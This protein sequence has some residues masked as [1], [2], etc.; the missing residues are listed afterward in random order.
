MRIIV[1][2]SIVILAIVPFF[3]IAQS[4]KKTEPSSKNQVVIPVRLQT[5][6]TG[7][8]K[9][10]SKQVVQPGKQGL[11]QPTTLKKETDTLKIKARDYYK[12]GAKKA[13][14][15]DYAGAIKDFSKS[16]S[17]NR[18][19]IILT[20]RAYAYMLNSQYDSAIVDATEANN[21]IKNNSEA[22]MILGISYY[23]KQNLD[24]AYKFLI[25]AGRLQKT[26]PMIY[27]YLAAIK[28]LQKDYKSALL[29]YD[30]VVMRDSSYQD[31]FSNRGMMQHYLGN[32]QDAVND[33]SQAIK[34][35]SI[36]ANAYNNRAAARII[37][38]D[39]PPALSDLNTAIRL[40]PG[41]SNAYENR[42][43]VKLQMGDKEGACQDWTK[44][45]SMGLESS[46]ELI[47]KHCK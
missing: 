47:I 17:Y 24:E 42:G 8:S 13:E 9:S 35:D 22:L 39:Y 23:E 20:K 15:K 16:L 27:D 45:L 18:N 12:S 21:K 4:D 28:F 25:K 30:S 37:L 31:V 5:D 7:K 44:A 40:N 1:Q 14:A 2:A 6:T 34:M 41:Y 36:D 33:Y 46:K 19:P 3:G 26:N 10:G 11:T 43:K 38:K 32:Y 29:Y